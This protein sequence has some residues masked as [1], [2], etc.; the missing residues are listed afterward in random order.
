MLSYVMKLMPGNFLKQ[1]ALILF[2]AASCLAR[3]PVVTLYSANSKHVWN[4]LYAA[5]LVRT[6][7]GM[8]YDDP[9]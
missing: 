6:S 8:A 7:E 4:R 1:F 2:M 5:L 3:E 9:A